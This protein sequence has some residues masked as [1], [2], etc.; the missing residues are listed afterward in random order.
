MISSQM[1]RE[2]G[3][4]SVYLGHVKKVAQRAQKYW[5]RILFFGEFA[6]TRYTPPV[7]GDI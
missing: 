2:Q 4:A 1:V 5:K 6:D 3:A 7:K